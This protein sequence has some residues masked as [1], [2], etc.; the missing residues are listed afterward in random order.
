MASLASRVKVD[1]KVDPKG[2][3]AHAEEVANRTWQKL[4]KEGITHS[5][6]LQL[7]KKN[8]APAVHLRSLPEDW[9]F[10]E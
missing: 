4:E 2:L 3:L 8:G 9:A 7:F 10:S 1:W 6:H 5:S